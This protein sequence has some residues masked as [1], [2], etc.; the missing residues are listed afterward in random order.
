MSQ[1][2]TCTSLAPAQGLRLRTADGA[3]LCGCVEDAE[4]REPLFAVP[5]AQAG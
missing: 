1:V 5:A 3:E 2:V 4:S